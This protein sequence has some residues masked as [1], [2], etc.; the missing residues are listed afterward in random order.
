[1][2]KKLLL[3]LLLR[4]LTLNVPFSVLGFYTNCLIFTDCHHKPFLF[5][6]FLSQLYFI[7]YMTS[8]QL[9]LV[10]AVSKKKEY[11]YNFWHY[12]RALFYQLSLQLVAFFH[13]ELLINYFRYCPSS[14][15]H[16]ALLTALLSQPMLEL[17]LGPSPRTPHSCQFSPLY[18]C[19]HLPQKS[20]TLFP[21]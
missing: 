8:I 16:Q 21:A 20:S 2:R 19:H 4:P 6:F 9:Q 5:L 7:L 10:L 1:M 3:T 12:C 15:Q 11:I 14:L 13:D 17:F 18:S